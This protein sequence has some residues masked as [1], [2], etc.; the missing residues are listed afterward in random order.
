M[1]GKAQRLVFGEKLAALGEGNSRIVVLDADVCSSTQ[2]KHFGNKFPDRFFNFGIAEANMVSA[3][4]GFASCGMIPF[5]STFALFLAMR[6]GDQVRGQIGYTRLNVKLMGGYGGLSDF[7]DGASHQ[8]VEDIA[9]MRT[10]PNMTVIA[11]A[12]ITETQQAVEAAANFDGPC[13]VRLSREAVG[14]IF[15]SSYRFEIGKGVTVQEGSDVTIISTGTMLAIALEAAQRCQNEGISARVINMA[16]I[17]PLD[18]EIVIDAARETGAI[19]TVEEASILGG[20]GSGVCETVT[21]S[22]PV[23]VSRIGLMDRF[24]ESGKYPELLEKVGLS[25]Q[26]IFEESRDVISRKVTAL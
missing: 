7:A 2:T 8:A 26:H 17:K 19:V 11:P 10:I 22:C 20:L 4:A 15:D 1:S 14:E 3:A 18:R 16:T 25:A 23:P 9:V 6:A 21:Q 12:D 13:F 24:G 5:V